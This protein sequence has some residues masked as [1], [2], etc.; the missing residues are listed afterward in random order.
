MGKIT[1]RFVLAPAVRILHPICERLVA[2]LLQ[3]VIEQHHI[4][5]LLVNCTQLGAGVAE[6]RL[7]PR[8]HRSR[9]RRRSRRRAL[10]KLQVRSLG[11]PTDYRATCWR[12]R[13]DDTMLR[14]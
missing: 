1:F 6:V 8:A 10:L 13:V 3:P 2:A 4:A 14:R 7:D 12:H 9:V 5:V 11:A